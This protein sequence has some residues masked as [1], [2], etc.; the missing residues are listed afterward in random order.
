MN[1]VA[2]IQCAP[3]FMDLAASVAKAIGLAEDAA[4]QGAQ[5]VAFGETWLPGYPAWL[6][7]CGD[8][9]LW[10]HAPSKEVF[11][12]LRQNSIVVP[13]PETEQFAQLRAIII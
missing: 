9:A 10:D 7:Y 3:I 4:R 6:D 2:L 13:G 11:A 12:R 1:R 5:L 8:A